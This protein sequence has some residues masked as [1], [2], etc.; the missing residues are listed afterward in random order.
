[1]DEVDVDAQVAACVVVVFG[2]WSPGWVPE[3]G[4]FLE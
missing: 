1:M 3:V 2:L 4:E